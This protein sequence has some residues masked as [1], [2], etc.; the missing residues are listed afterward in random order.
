MNETETRGALGEEGFILFEVS[1]KWANI[2]STRTTQSLLPRIQI[3]GL[4]SQSVR[5]DLIMLCEA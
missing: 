1:A 2:V 3:F 5:S 4:G